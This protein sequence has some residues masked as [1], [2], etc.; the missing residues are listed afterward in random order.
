MDLLLA[1]LAHAM[2]AFFFSHEGSKTIRP[3]KNYRHYRRYSR[4]SYK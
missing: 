3:H 1:Q 2:P 4:Y